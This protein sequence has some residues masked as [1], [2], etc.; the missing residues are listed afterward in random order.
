MLAYD[1][2]FISFDQNRAVGEGIE[3]TTGPT[4]NLFT[5]KAL[6]FTWTGIDEGFGSSSSSAATINR[7]VGFASSPTSRACVSSFSANNSTDSDCASAW[8]NTSCITI[9]SGSG[10]L[11]GQVDVSGIQHGKVTLIV[12]RALPP[13]TYYRVMWEAWGGSDITDVTI[14][15][16]A[17]PSAVG[18]QTYNASGFEPRVPANHRVFL[19]DQCVMFAGVQTVNATDSPAQQDSGLYI[20]YLTNPQLGTTAYT[21]HNLVLCGNSDDASASMDTDGYVSDTECVSMVVIAGGNINAR[22]SGIFDG[23]NNFKL[24]WIARATTNRRSIY[25]AIKGGFWQSLN[26]V[27]EGQTLNSL[28]TAIN[29]RGVSIR[30]ASFFGAKRAKAG[31]LGTT[32]V[33]DIIGYGVMRLGRG[34]LDNTNIDLGLYEASIGCIDDNGLAVSR[35]EAHYTKGSCLSYTNGTD[36][37]INA[38]YSVSTA[39]IENIQLQTT[40]AGGVTNEFIGILLFGDFPPKTTSLGHPFVV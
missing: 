24:N 26:T 25:M 19:A 36:A 29:T 23:N 28:S 8:S 13:S 15:A 12:D 9:I 11:W 37:T 33:D 21:T 7:G 34:S 16:I 17:E 6:R 31:T 10:T 3:F 1:T 38:T 30:G 32:S 20:G 35:C 27:I 5:A 14:G 22:A 40:A 39:S 18:V 2:G 4:D